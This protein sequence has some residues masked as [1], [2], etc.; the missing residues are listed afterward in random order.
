MMVRCLKNKI[1][2][3]EDPAI[4][5][6]V[7]E[8]IHMESIGLAVGACYPV[9]GVSF[10]A[11]VPWYLLCEE[12]NDDYPTPFCFAF[13]ELV[14]RSISSGWSLSLGDSNV[15]SVSILPDRWAADKSFLERLIDGE[16]AAI[17]YFKELKAIECKGMQMKPT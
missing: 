5:R 10:R 6:H 16:P 7:E 13:F 14:D 15:G 4:R 8:Y 9:F 3:L 11:G 2:L 17:S 1:V 12:I